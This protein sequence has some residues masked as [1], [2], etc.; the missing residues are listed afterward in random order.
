MRHAGGLTEAGEVTKSRRSEIEVSEC[1]LKLLLKAIPTI[2]NQRSERGCE[3]L[4]GLGDVRLD[5]IVGV[6]KEVGR[7]EVD[8]VEV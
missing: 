6:A 5:P 1:T 7:C 8:L 4:V 2:R 3:V